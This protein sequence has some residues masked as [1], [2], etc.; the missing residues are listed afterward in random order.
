MIK[1]MWKNAFKN[2]ILGKNLENHENQNCKPKFLP[3]VGICGSI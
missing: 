2:L 1:S 3:D